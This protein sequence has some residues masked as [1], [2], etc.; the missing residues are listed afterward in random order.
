MITKSIIL[1]VVLLVVATDAYVRLAPFDAAKWNVDI[2]TARTK[3]PY[4]YGTTLTTAEP[5]ETA[6]TH[7]ARI[8]ADTPRTRV[9]AGSP[10]EGRISFVTRSLLWGFPDITTVS[11]QQQDGETQ[12]SI[13]ARQ[14]FGSND[15][16]VNK[17]RVQ[18]WVA[19]FD[20]TPS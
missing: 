3:A 9:L 18:N 17:A 20:S 6:L 19:A 14:R 11:A 15:H 1:A 12:V 8:A 16:G 7:M 13:F 2:E 4:G 10:Q 5:A